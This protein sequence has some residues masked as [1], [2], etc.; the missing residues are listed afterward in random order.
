MDAGDGV[1]ADGDGAGDS[2]CIRMLRLDVRI[3]TMEGEGAAVVVAT[4]TNNIKSNTMDNTSHRTKVHHYRDHNR[5]HH[6]TF[7][8]LQAIMDNQQS[9]C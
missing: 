4:N 8:S 7:S 5:H 1:D 9:P 3:T 6:L 2:V